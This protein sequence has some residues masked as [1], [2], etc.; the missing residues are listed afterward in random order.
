MFLFLHSQSIIKGILGN[1]GKTYKSKEEMQALLEKRFD[2][3]PKDKREKL[4]YG[5]EFVQMPSKEL[6][7]LRID[8]YP[9]LI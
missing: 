1:L 4:I 9:Y 3:L 6:R 7:R 8:V 5:K 2:Y